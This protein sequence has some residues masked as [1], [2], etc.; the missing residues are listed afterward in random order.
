MNELKPCPFCGSKDVEVNINGLDSYIECG[1]C[2]AVFRQ[3][4]ACNADETIEAW[5]K[6]AIR[7]KHEVYHFDNL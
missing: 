3:R 6:R 2:L 7:T 4:E 5:N 1:N